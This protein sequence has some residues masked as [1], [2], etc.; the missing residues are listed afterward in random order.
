MVHLSSK[1]VHSRYN[2]LVLSILFIFSRLTQPFITENMHINP[3]RVALDS[4][5]AWRS[6]LPMYQFL[7]LCH[8]PV[9]RIALSLLF[10]KI[11]VHVY[12]HMLYSDQYRIQSEKSILWTSYIRIRF[13]VINLWLPCDPGKAPWIEIQTAVFADQWLKALQNPE[14]HDVTFI[15]EDCHQLSAHKVM[16]CSASKFFSRVFGA[17]V[18]SDVSERLCWKQKYGNTCTIFVC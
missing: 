12:T 3:K 15:V 7:L 8:R 2:K 17:T 13:F 9:M 5:E 10:C 4:S 11:H 16:L 14:H 18:S 6:T 1:K